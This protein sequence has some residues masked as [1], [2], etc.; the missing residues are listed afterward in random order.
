MEAAGI[1]LTDWRWAFVFRG[2][3]A[4]WDASPLPLGGRAINGAESVLFEQTDSKLLKTLSP[5]A[6]RA[7]TFLGDFFRNAI[8]DRK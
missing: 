6:S 4:K 5:M 7:A 2:E 3:G 1:R 8:S